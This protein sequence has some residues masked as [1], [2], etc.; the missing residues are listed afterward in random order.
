MHR[1]EVSILSRILGWRSKSAALQFQ[2]PS[3]IPGSSQ[4]PALIPYSTCQKLLTE[5]CT[6]SSEP[7]KWNCCARHPKSSGLSSRA[8][9]KIICRASGSSASLMKTPHGTGLA[10][11][12]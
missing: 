2:E 3:R 4:C 11:G 10:S 7:S 12:G 8:S 6:I 9:W 1:S 5:K